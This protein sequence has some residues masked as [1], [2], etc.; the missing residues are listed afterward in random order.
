M[1][2][3]HFTYDKS[4]E[5]LCKLWIE[6]RAFGEAAET[7]HLL[8]FPLRIRRRKLEPRLQLPDLLSA[9][10]PFGEHVDQCSIDVVDAVPQRQQFL[11]YWRHDALPRERF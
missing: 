6:A 7:R 2:M 9:F 1:V 5:F 3:D 10:E 11:R 4:Q 8:C